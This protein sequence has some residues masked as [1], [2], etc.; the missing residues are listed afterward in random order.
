MPRLVVFEV[1]PD[2][3][4]YDGVESSLYLLCNSTPSW[5]MVPVVL[6]S[7]NAKVMCTAVYAALHNT[8]SRQFA[9]YDEPVDV[10]GHRYVDGGFVER[11]VEHYSPQPHESTAIR[12]LQSQCAALQRC[13]DYLKKQGVPCILLEVPDTK[14]LMCSYDNLAE[15]QAQIRCYGNF[16]FKSLDTL[17]DSLHFY[18][19]THLNQEGVMLYN[20][21]VRDS[22]ILPTLD[23]LNL[24]R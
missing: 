23:S 7:R 21:F 13:V 18:D 6:R 15:F 4:S 19:D 16:Y 9:T 2:I 3:M 14:V 22:I 5:S 24:K 8:F 11:E 10:R 17:V 12:P 1:H 20:T